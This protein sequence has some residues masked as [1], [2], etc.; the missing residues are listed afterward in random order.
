MHCGCWTSNET[1]SPPAGLARST[2]CMRCCGNYWPAGP[3]PAC[4]TTPAPPS[5]IFSD[6]YHDIDS[7][8][9]RVLHNLDL[10]SSTNRIIAGQGT[11]SPIPALVPELA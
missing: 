3:R 1:T 9:E 10:R 4:D 11:L 2:S 8:T 6:G 7:L 5:S